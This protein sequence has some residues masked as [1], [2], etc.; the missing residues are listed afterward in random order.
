MKDAKTELEGRWEAVNGDKKIPEKQQ[1][2]FT[3]P[4]S[5][6]MTTKHQGVQQCNNYNNFAIIDDK[7]NIILGTYTSNNANDQLGLIPTI[8]NTE[9]TYGSLEGVQLGVDAGFFSA[10][11]IIY[12]EGKGI[13]YYAPYPEAKSPYAKDRFKYEESDDTYTCPGGNILKMEKQT[14]DGKKGLYSNERACV[15]CKT[16]GREC[17]NAN[18]GLRRIER[19]IE[20]DSVKEKAKEKAK[21]EE[22]REILQLRKTIPE[23]V[24]GNI[25]VQDGF[26][27]MHYRGEEKDS[28]E[29]RLH[30]LI[31]NIRKL[32]KVYFHSTSWQ[33]DIHSGGRIGESYQHTG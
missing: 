31:Q 1:I 23:P 7:A 21:S 19:D 3:D 24:C 2:N 32:L 4:D 17:T 10:D 30:C 14:E 8:E 5:C 33:E 18:D 6:I 9:K 12:T 22:G 11:N 25:K 26:T 28:L 20:N 16:V 15:S 13:D 29:F 27:Q